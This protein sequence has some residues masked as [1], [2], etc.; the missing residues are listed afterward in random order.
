MRVPAAACAFAAPNSARIAISRGSSSVV[1]FTGFL[2]IWFI[3]VL[4][5]V[6]SI[7]NQPTLLDDVEYPLLPGVNRVGLLYAK[8]ELLLTAVWF[9]IDDMRN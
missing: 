3:A 9:A 2:F 4:V 6:A 8:S 7:S 5:V 1:E